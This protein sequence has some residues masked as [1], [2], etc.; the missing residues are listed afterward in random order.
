MTQFRNWSLFCIFILLSLAHSQV[1]IAHSE[2]IA[3][4]PTQ[5]AILTTPPNKIRLQFNEPLNAGST[6]V[7]F[8]EAFQPIKLNPLIDE[9][10]PAILYANLPADLHLPAGFYTVQWLVISQD[11]HQISGSYRFQIIGDRDM[12][13]LAEGVSINLPGWF[14]WLMIILALATPAIVWNWAKNS[15]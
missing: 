5:G 7:L 15:K 13:I 4:L 8:N 9:S 10:K 12:E 1:V 14:A 3:T 11:G 2:L 6:F